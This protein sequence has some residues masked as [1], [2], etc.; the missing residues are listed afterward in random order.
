MANLWRIAPTNILTEDSLVKTV[1]GTNT[2]AL[3][4]NEFFGVTA[5]VTGTVAAT[6][7]NDTSA[8]A[9]TPVITGTSSTTGGDD[10]SSV[11][12]F[13]TITGSSS[14]TNQDDTSSVAAFSIISGTSSTTNADDVGLAAGGAV[15]SGTV[16]AVNLDDTSNASGGLVVTGTASPVNANDVGLAYGLVGNLDA[17]YF[18]LS[19]SQ[20]TTTYRLRYKAIQFN[21][22][23]PNIQATATKKQMQFSSFKFPSINISVRH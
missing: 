1:A 9:G 2:S 7:Q 13:T 8:A 5:G 11:T 19:F 18:T 6:N 16:A 20:P 23:A 14:T 17:R 12:A 3:V 15:I 21:L 4:V 22:A 10:T